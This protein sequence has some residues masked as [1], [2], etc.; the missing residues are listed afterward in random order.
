MQDEPLTSLGCAQLL[1]SEAKLN[2]LQSKY[3]PVTPQCMKNV[4]V[5]VQN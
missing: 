3:R 2:R 1:F 4:K 5:Y